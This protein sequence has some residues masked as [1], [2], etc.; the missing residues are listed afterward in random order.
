MRTCIVNGQCNLILQNS[1]RHICRDYII[2][3]GGGYNNT[4]HPTGSHFEW[5]S[6]LQ[7]IW[8]KEKGSFM[9]S[10]R[11]KF[12]VLLAKS[13]PENTVT[14]NFLTVILQQKKNVSSTSLRSILTWQ[15][16]PSCKYH[17]LIW[18]VW[19]GAQTQ[20]QEMTGFD[21]IR[22]QFFS[23]SSNC[24]LLI[25]IWIT[26]RSCI[27]TWQSWS[28]IRLTLVFCSELTQNTK[29]TLKSFGIHLNW[30]YKS[31]NKYNEKLKLQDTVWFSVFNAF[32]I[33]PRV[34]RFGWELSSELAVLIAD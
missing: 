11:E 12:I 9:K 23:T 32:S 27:H 24:L 30:K 19:S 31:M 25:T 16:V 29:I 22:R 2:I 20:E 3:N 17:C 7:K 21:S 10:G 1:K 26:H 14:H 4:I 28:W 34:L 18:R 33:R 8:S 15:A 13:W 6:A 5:R